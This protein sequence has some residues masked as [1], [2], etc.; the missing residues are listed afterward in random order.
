MIWLESVQSLCRKL[1]G[2][3][4]LLGD[5]VMVLVLQLFAAV[6][7]GANREAHILVDRS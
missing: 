5:V 7:Q 2:T 1:L 6:L 3:F 4:G